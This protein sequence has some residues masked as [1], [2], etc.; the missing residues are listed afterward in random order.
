M[1]FDPTIYGE[2]V[3]AVL[4]M[5]ENGQ[6]LMPL[7]A[8]STFRPDA[9]RMLSGARPLEWFHGAVSP[10]G[11]LAGLWLYFSC[12][13]EAH[14]IAQD[15]SSAEGSYW[16]AIVHRQEPDS[17]NSAYWFRRVGAHPIFHLL[18]DEAARIVKRH[19][20]LLVLGELFT[21]YAMPLAMLMS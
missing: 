11:A 2:K 5:A 6:R 20:T 19:P 14:Q 12:F 13:E 1:R 17:G 15:D 18:V 16:H 9:E 3:A 4:A 10:K 8:G 7:V 21:V